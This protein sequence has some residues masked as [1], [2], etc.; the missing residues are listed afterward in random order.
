M[1]PIRMA[2]MVLPGMVCSLKH[3][4]SPSDEQSTPF[5]VAVPSAQEAETPTPS[6]SRSFFY[7]IIPEAVPEIPKLEDP[8]N[9]F[10]KNFDEDIISDPDELKKPFE[11]YDPVAS[12]H[13]AMIPGTNR[14]I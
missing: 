6:T 2:G 5:P 4:T 1:A 11:L 10:V 12:V 14:S 3:E 9:L 8:A 7:V 13:L